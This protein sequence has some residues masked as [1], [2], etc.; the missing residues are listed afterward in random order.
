MASFLSTGVRQVELLVVARELAT[1][2][3]SSVD[4]DRR[5][6]SGTNLATLQP[7]NAVGI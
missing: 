5:N 3:R 1:S 4:M 2:M 6:A 7:S